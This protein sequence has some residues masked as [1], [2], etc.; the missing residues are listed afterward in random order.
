MVSL[1]TETDRTLF[2]DLLPIDVG[3]IGGFKTRL[4]LYTIPG[5]VFY[6]TTRKLV[7]KGVDG[8]VFVADSQL[9]ML[10]ANVE[11]FNNLRENL[12]EIG[13]N[14]D[15]IPLVLQINKRDLPN[16]AAIDSIIEMVD[17]ERKYEYVEAVA[18][19]G[20]GVFETL[21][22]ISKLTL[23]TL[24]RR[25]TGEEPLKTT[26]IRAMGGTA[27]FRVKED[28]RGTIAG[29]TAT[30]AVGTVAGAQPHAAPGA[31][32]S[33]APGAERP[34]LVAPQPLNVAEEIEELV[35]S[36]EVFAPLDVAHI[37][38]EAPI[39]EPPPPPA[40]PPTPAAPEPGAE[41]E[42]EI[43][44]TQSTKP[45]KKAQVKHVKVRT[46]V[47]I[48]AELETLRKKATQST[49]KPMK[50]DVNPLDE[51]L[52]PRK[53][54]MQKSVTLAVAPGVLH[55]S[56]NLRVAVSFENEDGVVQSQEQSVDLSDASDVKT[57]LVN[58]KFES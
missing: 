27:A 58:L 31:A 49:P 11:S 17:T 38:S 24:R 10:D 47:D 36:E 3:V 15:D 51:L 2:F 52:H 44:F 48:M 28:T 39:A 7:L 5:Q 35:A 34:T 21:K 4:Q 56:T 57:L 33:V 50:K 46:S 19:T 22:L 55:K 45:A 40:A 30:P 32:A 43:D 54:E 16:V 20:T 8:L 41:P 12:R 29:G 23:R 37:I 14:L 13:L 9:Q 25:M 42:P 6:N 18:S 53:R 26:P 1:E